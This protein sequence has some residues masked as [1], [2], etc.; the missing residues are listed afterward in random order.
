MFGK[1]LIANR[2]EIAV[3]IAGTARRMG[4]ATV[5][6]CSDAD[7]NALHVQTADE[8]FRVGPAPAQESYL[9]IDAILSIA[10]RSEAEAVHPGYGF[11]S[12]NPDFAEAVT[13][14][15]LV[16]I[17]PPASA[18]RA[19]GLKDEARRVM[20]KADIPVLPG[21]NG[22]NQSTEHLFREAASIG[23]PILIKPVAGGG[24]KGMRRVD[25]LNTFVENLE[26]ARREAAFAFG[27]DR[28]L[29]E[30][31][32]DIAR[33]IEIQ[34]FA[35]G[36]GNIVHLFE[37]DCSLQR[38]HQKVIEEAPAPGMSAEMRLLMG[39]TAVNA[40][41]AV[42]YEGAG[43]VEFIADASR[44][45]SPESF[46]FM[47][48]NTRLQVEH[49][50]TEMICGL[51]LVEWQLRIAGG[52]SL[53]LQQA[54]IAISGHAIEA[55]LYAEDPAKNFQPQSGKL[56]HL[57]FARQDDLCIDTGYQKGDIVT[58]YYDPMIAKVI[59]HGSTRAAALRKL[60][61]ALAETR[62]GGLRTNLAFLSRLVCDQSFIAG[63]FDTRFIDRNAEKLVKGGE[64]PMEAIAATALH[65]GGYLSAPLSLSPFD[66]LTNFRLWNAEAQNSE[67][68]IDGASLQMKLVN[69]GG[70][71]FT[72]EYRGG[73]TNFVLQD[74]DEDTV[75]ILR[76]D[77]IVRLAFFD[78]G[79]VLTIALGDTI[80][81]FTAT[82]AAHTL[83][84]EENNSNLVIA[85]MPG[86]VRVINVQPGDGVSKGD[87]IAVTEAMKME[88]SLPALRTGKIGKVNVSAG[89][90]IEEGRIIATIEDSDG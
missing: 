66:S 2:G 28:V 61:S 54:E 11:L 35:D 85:P 29:L 50:V 40:A 90:Q 10:K 67:F 32:M 37:R 34:I 16:F 80:H 59:S 58:S 83:G 45:L 26:G 57:Q 47:E 62:V 9:N 51:D 25:G 79:N 18:I 81:E 68:M 27:N 21:Y 43:T 74:L 56:K 64:P 60:A 82:S 48:M 88:F 78:D 3:R 76:G 70:L 89:E 22:E 13:R 87:I 73:S 65:A 53:P 30:K 52:E 75:H 5:A 44:G 49:R 42:G 36:H 84:M 69:T 55:R 6:I 46:Y 71:G 31:F 77:R 23:F 7:R 86:L 63:D 20:Q 72:L 39:K 14:A 8:V 33:H 4:I 15:G 24:G 1:I 12:E 38:R 19:M 41:K 17:G